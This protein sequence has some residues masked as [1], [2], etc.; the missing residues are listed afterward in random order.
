[1]RDAW[2]IFRG[3]HK[4]QEHLGG[5]PRGRDRGHVVCGQHDVAQ[6]LELQEIDDIDDVG[7]EVDVRIGQMDALAQPSERRRMHRMTG[8]TEKW[9]D[10]LPAQP[11]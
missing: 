9:G 8:R 2:T 1:M 5:F 10:S 11:P 7:I 3:L 4:R 6:I